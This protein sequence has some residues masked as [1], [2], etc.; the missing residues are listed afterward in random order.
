VL[1]STKRSV[2]SA[3]LAHS[4]QATSISTGLTPGPLPRL[5][6]ACSEQDR[7]A[8][9]QSRRRFRHGRAA[10]QGGRM[11][12][13]WARRFMVILRGLR[14]GTGF[15]Y[16]CGPAGW[17]AASAMMPISGADFRFSSSV[18]PTRTGKGSGIKRNRRARVRRDLRV[19]ASPSCRTGRHTR[20]RPG[21]CLS[22]VGYSAWWCV[23]VSGEFLRSERSIGS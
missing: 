5:L 8:L 15:R 3:V 17:R 16:D 9:I 18:L 2:I 19:L 20:A 14:D 1:G 11:L 4:G 21:W 10:G 13:T 12:S 22:R 23:L 7:F 6:P